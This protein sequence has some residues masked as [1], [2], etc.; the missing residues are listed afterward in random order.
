VIAIGFSSSI[1]PS[2]AQNARYSFTVSS[3]SFGTCA[4]GSPAAS[5][6]AAACQ[7]RSPSIGSMSRI[8][9]ASGCSCATA[10]MST[11]PRRETTRRGASGP[12]AK[13]A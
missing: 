6:A 7:V 9:I 11:P 4:D 3:A 2:L 5:Q 12:N 13:L 1:R 10:S 8:T